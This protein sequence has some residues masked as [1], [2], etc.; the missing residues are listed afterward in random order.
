MKD[1]EQGGAGVASEKHSENQQTE[2]NWK[3]SVIL[4]LHDLL[5]MLTA[6]FS[7]IKRKK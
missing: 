4:Y 2:N 5:Y 6:I 3:K 7:G 1:L